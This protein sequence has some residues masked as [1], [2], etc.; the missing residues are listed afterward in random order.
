MICR[1]TLQ[2]LPMSY[3]ST[4]RI[5]DIFILLCI[6]KQ[7]VNCTEDTSQGC[8]RDVGADADTVCHLAGLLIHQVDIGSRLCPGTG[9]QRMLAVIENLD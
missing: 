6:S 1:R 7:T 2:F 8:S 3:R 5:S 4:E 9:C